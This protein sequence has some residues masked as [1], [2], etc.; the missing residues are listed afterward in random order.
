MAIVLPHSIHI[1]L[2]SEFDDII[3]GVVQDSSDPPCPGRAGFTPSARAKIRALISQEVIPHKLVAFWG[4]V[5]ILSGNSHILYLLCQIEEKKICF[6]TADKLK[7]HVRISIRR[8]MDLVAGHNNESRSTHNWSTLKWLRSRILFIIGEWTHGSKSIGARDF[9]WRQ[10]VNL[11]QLQLTA[12][13]TWTLFVLALLASA[14]LVTFLI[15]FSYLFALFFLWKDFLFRFFAF[16]VLFALWK[17]FILQINI[18]VEVN[19]MC[20]IAC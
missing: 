19:S 13:C 9:D 2:V 16:L 5:L 14:C 17:C 20:L 10:I 15:K 7:F 4:L 12:Q 1:K 3:L 11:N 6:P 8:D 18:Y